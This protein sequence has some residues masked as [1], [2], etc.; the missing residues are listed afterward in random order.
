[1]PIKKGLRPGRCGINSQVPCDD[2]GHGSHTTST[3]VGSD[4]YG[5][6]P[7][8]QWIACRNMDQG[9]GS[10]STYLDCLEFFLA[11]TNLKG[12]KPNAA[13]RPHVIGNSYGCPSREGCAPLAFHAAVRTLQ[14][15]GILMSVS[16]GND[17]P[18]CS[19]ISDPPAYE[20]LVLTVGASS[21]MSD[22]IAPFSSRGPIVHVGGLNAGLKPQVVA[23]GH[24]VRG[25]Y[26]D[27][28]FAVLSGTSMA[29]PHVSGAL[30][31][32]SAAR[33]DLE[34]AV[35]NELP[36][37]LMST[38]RP[39]L[40]KTFGNPVCGSDQPDSTPNNIYGYGMIRVN[41]AFKACQSTL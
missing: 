13:R 26:L 11:P 23:P 2:S 6:A 40:S 28:G 20:P 36:D 21:F 31:L 4:G 32:L 38:A 25:A 17:G 5:V 19:S 12:E 41:E 37:L 9:V 33:P 30:L 8:A 34:R 27:G 15:A 35:D 1:M 16:A 7:D 10:T 39:I 3:V 18:E 14:K 24:R 29:S 22:N